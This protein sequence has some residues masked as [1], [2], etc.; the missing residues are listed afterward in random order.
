MFYSTSYLLFIDLL[1]LIKILPILYLS[2]LMYHLFIY[3]VNDFFVQFY[4]N[5]FII[6]LVNHLS[7]IVTL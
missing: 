2:Y 6:Y 4:I 7:I 5:F 1:I 3:P